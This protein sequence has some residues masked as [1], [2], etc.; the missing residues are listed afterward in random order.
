[1][2]AYLR[3]TQMH[4]TPVMP[5]ATLKMR[6]PVTPKPIRKGH[7]WNTTDISMEVGR[8]HTRQG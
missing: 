7:L 6:N 3:S 1:M 2:P 4:Y 5:A 8:R